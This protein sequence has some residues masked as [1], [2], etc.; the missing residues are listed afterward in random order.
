[1]DLVGDSQT[2]RDGRKSDWEKMERLFP[3]MK[4]EGRLGLAI[5]L[6][7]VVVWRRFFEWV[8]I[9]KVSS[10]FEVDTYYTKDE[11]ILLLNK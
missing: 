5:W 3:E 10:N 8:L 11:A 4:I 1:M 7:T 9:N 2:K 6:L